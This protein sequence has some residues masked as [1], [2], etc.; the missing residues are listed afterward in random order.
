[1]FSRYVSC[2]KNVNIYFTKAKELLI[3]YAHLS[4]LLLDRTSVD[5]GAAFGV[6]TI[7]DHVP[8]ISGHVIYRSQVLYNALC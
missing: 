4:L 6:L 1:M 8:C 3:T 2:E 5:S 7:S